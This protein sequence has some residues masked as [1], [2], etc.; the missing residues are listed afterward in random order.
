MESISK[1]TERL[2]QI[3][4]G[5]RAYIHRGIRALELNIYQAR[6][7]HYVGAHPGTMQKKL[8]SYLGKSEAT[9]T[10]I[11]KVLQ[12]RDLI[13]RQVASGNERQKELRLTAAGEQKVAEVHAVFAT[14][15]TDMN[16]QLDDTERAELM[17]LLAKVAA[18]EPR[19]GQN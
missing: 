17:R 8:A 3:H 6:T 2:F 19:M 7:L 4:R 10:N 15:E 12:A 18:A 9:V 11:L 14:L 5:E 16:A 1:L 13:D